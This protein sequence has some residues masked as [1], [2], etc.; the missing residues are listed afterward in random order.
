MDPLR[1]AANESFLRLHD[2]CFERCVTGLSS[3]TLDENEKSC[4]NGCFKT[5][6]TAFKTSQKA[7]SDHFSHVVEKP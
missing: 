7:L 5:F 2:S 6:A 4:L 3:A 1:M